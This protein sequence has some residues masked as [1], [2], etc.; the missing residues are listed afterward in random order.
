[1]EN[2]SLIESI[3]SVIRQDEAVGYSSGQRELDQTAVGIAQLPGGKLEKLFISLSDAFMDLYD[4]DAS[5]TEAK[6]VSQELMKLSKRV[7]KV[8]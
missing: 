2:K 1:M 3:T 5:Q 4:D 7:R 6:A 8:N